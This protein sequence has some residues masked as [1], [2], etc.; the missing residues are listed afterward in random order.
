M[1]YS[2]KKLTLLFI[3][4]TMILLSSISVHAAI[5]TDSV[6]IEP[7]IVGHAALSVSNLY[8]IADSSATYN[9]TVA[10]NEYVLYITITAYAGNEYD[11]GSGTLQAIAYPYVSNSWV[12]S[13]NSIHKYEYQR[14]ITLQIYNN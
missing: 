13:A 10:R 2:K 5:K 8:G 6:S 9:N 1:H 3:L 11:T 4:S 7:N 14:T 12:T